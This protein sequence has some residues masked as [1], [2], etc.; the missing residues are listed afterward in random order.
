MSKLFPQS[1]IPGVSP[2]GSCVEIHVQGSD[3]IVLTKAHTEKLIK[4][5]TNVVK[6]ANTEGKP[7]NER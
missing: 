4:L 3:T 1:L 7:N 5:L 6:K 2:D